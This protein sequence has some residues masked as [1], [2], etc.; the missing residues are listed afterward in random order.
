MTGAAQAAARLTGRRAT[1]ERRGG[2]GLAEVVLEG[3]AVV[4]VKH[5][6]AP[7][8]VRVPLHQLFPLLV[9]TVLFGGGYA[10]QAVAAARAALAAR[11]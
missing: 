9:H 10:A 3:G 11:P 6:D 1:G 7:G 5:A 2:G 8:A 4:V